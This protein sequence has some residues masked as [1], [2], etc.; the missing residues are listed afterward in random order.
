M[1]AED[2][3]INTAT[4]PVVIGAEKL[5]PE[6]VSENVGI[7]NEF[8]GATIFGKLMLKFSLYEEK[9]LKTPSSE[10]APTVNIL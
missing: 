3:C 10:Q 1:S 7:D 9:E 5:V 2:F 4:A 6:C 8:P